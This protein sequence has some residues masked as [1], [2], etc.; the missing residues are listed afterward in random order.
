MYKCYSIIFG[1][2]SPD[3]WPVIV[4]LF[5][6][7]NSFVESKMHKI[8]P[9]VS[10]VLGSE[11]ASRLMG[12][13][14]GLLPLSKIPACNLEVLGAKKKLLAGYSNTGAAIQPHQGRC[15]HIL[16]E[17]N[18]TMWSRFC[19]NLLLSSSDSEYRRLEL[20]DVFGVK[21]PVEFS[22]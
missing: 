7:I 18:Y 6:Q 22:V 5:T 9:N 14:G 13:A 19:E 10:L 17:L 8:A 3:A 20:L 16:M 4:H 2:L 11:T 15:S 1:V 12:L 21:N